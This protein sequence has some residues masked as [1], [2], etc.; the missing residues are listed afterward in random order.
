MIAPACCVIKYA[1]KWDHYGIEF[2]YIFQQR[3]LEMQLVPQLVSI[4]YPAQHTDR[5]ATATCSRSTQSHT[6]SISQPNLSHPQLS[7]MQRCPSKHNHSLP[8]LPPLPF[9]VQVSSTIIETAAEGQIKNAQENV[10]TPNRKLQTYLNTAPSVTITPAVL[11]PVVLF[12]GNVSLK[13]LS[14]LSLSTVWM[15]LP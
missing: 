11:P 2:L 9:P 15:Q 10:G 5:L 8:P 7:T 6:P 13:Q 14:A 4:L 1:L 12:A 3:L